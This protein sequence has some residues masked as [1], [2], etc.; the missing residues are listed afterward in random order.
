MR[1]CLYC[2][3]TIERYSP[4]CGDPVSV[5]SPTGNVGLAFLMPDGLVVRLAGGD[6]VEVPRDQIAR[7]ELDGGESYWASRRGVA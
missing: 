7:V 6:Y 2:K 1:I 5:H 4:F 3:L